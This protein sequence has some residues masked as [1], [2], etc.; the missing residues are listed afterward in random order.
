MLNHLPNILTFSRI[1]LAPA[2]VAVYFLPV[3]YID[4][5]ALI[6]F[7][8]A[9]ITDFLDGYLARTFSKQSR[10]G[11]LFDPIAD[12]L[13]VSV[14]IVMLVMNDSII[15]INIIPGIIIL[16]REIV[17]SSLRAFLVESNGGETLPVT[18]LTKFKTT[19]QIISLCFL[20]GGDSLDK[21]VPINSMEMGIWF[22]WIAAIITI[23]T[24]YDLL[25]KGLL[26]IH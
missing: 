6:I 7:I 20:L 16:S 14:A 24:G 21:I 12:K 2:L 22:L 25:R 4:W 11:T 13:I 8:I 23:Y 5:V 17:I 18:K 19:I 26:K 15:G 1:I 10:I 3:N 9:G